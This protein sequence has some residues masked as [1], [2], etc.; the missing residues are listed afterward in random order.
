MIQEA[1]MKTP[2]IPEHLYQCN[3]FKQQK[4]WCHKALIDGK[5]LT[6]PFLWIKG[7]NQPWRIIQSL[8]KSGLVIEDLRV[9]TK[10]AEGIIHTNTPAWKIN[11]NISVSLH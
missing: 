8:R 9:S 10:D 5:T 6:E 11:N 1:N 4:D 3:S 2:S 7:V